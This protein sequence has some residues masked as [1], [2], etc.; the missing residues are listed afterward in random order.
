[1][2]AVAVDAGPDEAAE[3]QSQANGQPEQAY[4]HASRRRDARSLNGLESARS[5]WKNV[6]AV[7]HPAEGVSG[8]LESTRTGRICLKNGVT[9]LGIAADY[10]PIPNTS[11]SGQ[12]ILAS[13]DPAIN[14][15]DARCQPHRDHAI[16]NWR[17]HGTTVL[18]V[19]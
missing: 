8:W 4:D 12:L 13:A 3:Q 15:S 2:L 9:K 6:S 5:R 18:D 7:S 10:A 17:H 1:M 16:A 14:R 19:F 11:C